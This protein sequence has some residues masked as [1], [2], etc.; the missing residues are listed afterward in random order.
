MIIFPL[1]AAAR[2][3]G[4]FPPVSTDRTHCSQGPV[5]LLPS[6]VSRAVQALPCTALLQLPTSPVM[7]KMG[8]LHKVKLFLALV[9]FTN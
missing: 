5:L 6:L 3:L 2:G 9:G 4:D 1:Y 8:Q 7:S